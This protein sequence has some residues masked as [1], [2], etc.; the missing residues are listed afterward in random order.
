MKAVIIAAAVL[1]LCLSSG[2]SSTAATKTFMVVKE[3]AS[4]RSTASADRKS[5]RGVRSS[6]SSSRYVNDVDYDLSASSEDQLLPL[7]LRT[8]PAA[9][10]AAAA[11]TAVTAVERFLSTNSPLEGE[12]I[13]TDEE[14][15]KTKS[16]EL[17]YLFYTDPPVDLSSTSTK[18]CFM[19][20]NNVFYIPGTDEE[21]SVTTLP[22]IQER[23]YCSTNDNDDSD[24][25]APTPVPTITTDDEGEEGEEEDGGDIPTYSPTSTS[26]SSGG[27][28]DSTTMSLSM[29]LSMPSSLS[30]T[31]TTSAMNSMEGT[32]SSTS[33]S[34]SSSSTM[35][36]AVTSTMS[37]TATT[38][39]IPDPF[40]DGSLEIT[41]I[42]SEVEMESTTT[43][44]G[45]GEEEE[46]LSLNDIDDLSS[47]GA[48]I[49]ATGLLDELGKIGPF[50]LFGKT[51]Y[52]YFVCS[53]SYFFE[54]IM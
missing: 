30:P 26:S 54:M 51:M 22:G 39:T 23:V 29:S 6:S 27:D 50:T 7:Q 20:N 11:A 17:G 8:P 31:S 18:G 14:E 13:C 41:P 45:G 9:P 44:A 37:T 53:S 52:I 3:V 16:I 38:T 49:G 25:T 36:T 34:T 4:S 19:K 10:A 43:T 5:R 33:S 32:Y 40:D 24:V 12:T 47:L 2:S 46:D 1:G 48:L 21:M 42:I 35:S 28:D 15:C